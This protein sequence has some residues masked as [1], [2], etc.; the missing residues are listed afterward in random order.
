LA[1]YSESTRTSRGGRN[2]LSEQYI[3][4]IESF[5]LK[6]WLLNSHSDL[7]N[8]EADFVEALYDILA[9]QVGFVLAQYAAYSETRGHQSDKTAASL[10]KLLSEGV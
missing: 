10:Q 1:N 4:S 7:R 2:P 6:E 9:A 3:A 8:S 5:F